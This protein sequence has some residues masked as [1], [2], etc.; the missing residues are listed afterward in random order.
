MASI[1]VSQ[2]IDR[3]PE[4]VFAFVAV[5]HLRNHPRWDPNMKLE[6]L[7]QQEMGVGARFKR[8]H[9]RTGAPIEGEMEVVE[10]EPGRSMAMVIRD[11]TPNGI[12]NVQSRMVVEPQG[13]RASKLTISVDIPAM[14][15]SMDPR[16][17]ETSLHNMKRLIESET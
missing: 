15:E 13:S 2:V 17:I 10:F 8:T 11:M 16:M 4:V 3:P 5:N 7:T 6:Q 14:H 12:L 1:S 9:T